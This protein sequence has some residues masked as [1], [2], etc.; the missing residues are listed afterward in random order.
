MKRILFLLATLIMAA[1]CCNNKAQQAQ[2]STIQIVENKPMKIDFN[3]IEEQCIPAFKG[4]EK[5]FRVK[6]YTDELNKIMKGRLVPGASIGMHTHE[7]NSEIMFITKGCG[8]VIFD[9]EK[10]ALQAGDVHYCPKGHS[11]S[12]VNDSDADLE[13]SAVVPQQ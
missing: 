11:H 2:P 1:S 9:G 8:Y 4:G 6:M 13:F 10:I 12:L 7:G 5:E 3:T